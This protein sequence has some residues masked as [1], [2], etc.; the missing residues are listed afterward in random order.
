MG[1][2][3]GQRLSDRLATTGALVGFKIVLVRGLQMMIA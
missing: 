1:G 3:G 2:V